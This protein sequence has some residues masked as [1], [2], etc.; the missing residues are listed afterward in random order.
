MSL[1]RVAG[2]VLGNCLVLLVLL[3]ISEALYRAFHPGLELYERTFPNPESLLEEGDSDYWSRTDPELGWVATGKNLHTF[4]KPTAQWTLHVNKQGFRSAVDYDSLPSK[5]DATRVMILGDSFVFGIYL[6]QPDTLSARL[7]EY[8]GNG[9]EVYNVGIPGWGV[10]Q[11]FLAYEKFVEAIDPDVVV[12]VYINDDIRRVFEAETENDKPS[13]RLVGDDLV[14]RID[15][16]PG[17]WDW[18]AAH[19]YLANHVYARIVRPYQS[20]RIAKAFIRKLARETAARHQQ[21]VVLRYPDKTEV[22]ADF[23]EWDVD[24]STFFA[25]EGITHLDPLREMRA[26]SEA[27]RQTFY[28]SFDEH[29]ARAG[30]SLVAR[31]IATHALNRP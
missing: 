12:L 24:L 16:T 8:L 30:N 23:K 3:G 26:A 17:W 4:S 19:S 9:S 14:P 2:L 28:L 21:F 1:R 20:E 25:D 7:E 10:D 22:V 18:V 27:E 6:D 15:D 13:F 29:P 31:Y 11:M 5:G